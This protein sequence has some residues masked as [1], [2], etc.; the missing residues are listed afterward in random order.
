MG[1][2]LILEH[3]DTDFYCNSC[4]WAKFGGALGFPNSAPS[5]GL[6]A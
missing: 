6:G 3:E 5:G 2:I 4:A 1:E